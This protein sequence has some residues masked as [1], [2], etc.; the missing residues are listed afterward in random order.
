MEPDSF[1]WPQPAVWASRG[2]A[3][4][5]GSSAHIVSHPQR[6]NLSLPRGGNHRSPSSRKGLAPCT[7]FSRSLLVLCY[8]CHF[9]QVTGSGPDSRQRTRFNLLAREQQHC[10]AQ[11][12]HWGRRRAGGGGPEECE[13]TVICHALSLVSPV[14]TS[15]PTCLLLQISIHAVPSA[16]G[17]LSSISPDKI[18]QHSAQGHKTSLTTH[19]LRG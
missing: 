2:T 19:P 14:A 12:R 4:K 1:R 11:G 16:W 7:A 9:E 17:A 8:S 15:L 3:K 13:H 5:A 10:L 6:A 18:F